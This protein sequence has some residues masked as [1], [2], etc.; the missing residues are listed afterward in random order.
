MTRNEDDALP[1]MD[2]LRERVQHLEQASQWHH[3]A[4]DVL[5]SMT[6]IFG[7]HSQSRDISAILESTHEC[8]GRILPLEDAGY[9]TVDDESSF[10]L[11]YRQAGC[12]GPALEAEVE[13]LIEAGIFSWALNQN[14]PVCLP[15]PGGGQGEDDTACGDHW[16]LHVISSRTR[17]R[18]M[19][20]GRT[21]GQ[22][23]HPRDP[24][25]KVLS[26]ILFNAAYALESAALY[27]L[28]EHQHRT[29]KKISERQ[30][31][32]LAHQYSHDALTGLPNRILFSDRLHQ[33]I[34]QG[35]PNDEDDGSHVAVILMDLDHFKRV[36]DSLGHGCGDRLIKTLADNL[37]ALLADADLLSHHHLDESNVTLSRLGGDEFGII[38][39]RVDSLDLLARFAQHLIDNVS[40]EYVVHGHPVFLTCSAGIS[41]HPFDGRDVDTLIKNADA[42]M[43]EAKQRGRNHYHFYTQDINAQTYR[44]L[45]LENELSKA[46]ER[47]EFQ[48]HYQPQ[49]SLA[50]GKVEGLEAL[51]RWE[52]PEK[53]YLSP[54]HFIPV[55]E[56]TG[57]IERLGLW[58]VRRACEDMKR[59][60]AADLPV[61][62]MAINLSPRQFRQTDLA[63]QYAAII[64]EIGIQASQIELELT[65]STIM[66]DIDKAVEIFEALH[67]LGFRLAVDDF[68]TGYSS[69]NQLKHFPIHTLKI[70]RS[71]VRGIPQDRDDAAIVTAIVAMAKGLGLE[72]VAEGVEARHQ[73]EFLK[74]L[75]CESVQ[76]YYFSRPLPYDELCEYLQDSCSTNQQ[77]QSASS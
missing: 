37:R 27:T 61:P 50:T 11:S 34:Q 22:P 24:G 8:V 12:E 75:E 64:K 51:V 58:V 35:H 23:L 4:M 76:G 77:K 67:R 20:V 28:M 21:R 53:G 15:C 60:E 52:H 40:C 63:C 68:G 2:Y 39:N 13:R 18:G 5:T 66:Q 32:E 74:A 38:L 25:M 14:H 62:R 57:L 71:F 41:I 56:D 48:L 59:L 7:D 36:N 17:I 43:Y 31:L 46:L 16:V 45:M 6:A 33:L 70:D 10:H 42:A 26:I 72:V 49:I 65:E 3:Y 69:L 30:S 54:G 55:A 44:H 47:D 1:D 29:L 73:L 9:Y 19:F